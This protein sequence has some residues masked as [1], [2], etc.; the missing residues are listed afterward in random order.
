[1]LCSIADVLPVRILG[2]AKKRDEGERER[3]RERGGEG[4]RERGGGEGRRLFA[5][6]LQTVHVDRS[7]MSFCRKN[8]YVHESL[9]R[10]AVSFHRLYCLLYPLVLSL[11]HTFVG[12]RPPKSRIMNKS[13]LFLTINLYLK[14]KSHIA[15]LVKFYEC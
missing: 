2:K 3:E 13:T 12:F 6:R 5:A 15:A 4:E 1:M 10:F 7:V 8:K 14:I 11:P 9:T